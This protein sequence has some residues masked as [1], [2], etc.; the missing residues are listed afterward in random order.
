MNL[1]KNVIFGYLV[2]ATYCV[3]VAW[4]LETA[5]YVGT[6]LVDLGLV[7]IVQVGY[8]LF[9][10]CV[11]DSELNPLSCALLPRIEEATSG[12]KSQGNT[13]PYALTRMPSD[14]WAIPKS[15]G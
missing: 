1:S 12:G 9:C 13:C 2:I 5:I 7:I 11:E 3:V 6:G 4:N 8:L 14:D 15:E 10:P